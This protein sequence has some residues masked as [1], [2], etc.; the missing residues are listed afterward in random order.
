MG[1]SSNNFGALRL[2]FAVLVILSHSL[3]LVDGNRSREI[4]TRIFGTLSFGELG[5]DGFFLISGYLVTKSFQDSRSAGEYVLKRVLR[6]YPGYVVA[7]LLCLLALGPFVG[8]QAAALSIGKVLWRMVLLR[9]PEMEGVFAGT[10]N[11]VLNGSMWTIKYEFLCYL[12]VLAAG[13][14]GLLSKRFILSLLTVGALALSAVLQ[15][16]LGWFPDRLINFV[17]DPGLIVRFIGVF[18]CGALFYLYRDRIRYDRRLSTL[19]GCGLMVMM[20][21]PR[22][23]VAAL[24]ILGGYVL[25]WFAFNVKSPTL[26]AVG[27]KVDLSYGVYLY[28]WPVQMLLIWLDPGISPW[29]VFIEATA[30]AGIFAFGSWWLVEKP[31][32]NLKAAFL[33][34]VRA[35]KLEP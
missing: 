24:S 8:G 23:A 25:F 27:Q 17:G 22:L 5:V 11:A 19:A 3:E 9:A 21:S 18:G 31:F 34:V 30:I 13:L 35:A 15:N 33:P 29:L 14:I 1:R 28:A 2:L 12:L 7:Y 6:I 32:L 26:A 16:I 10:P 20:F 4:L